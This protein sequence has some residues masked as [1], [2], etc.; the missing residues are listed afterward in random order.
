MR[1]RLSLAAAALLLAGSLPALAQAFPGKR[2]YVANDGCTGHAYRPSR[3]TLACGDG[4]LYATGISYRTYGQSVARASARIHLND[5]IPN[6][7]T[8]RFH[9][10]RGTL[11]L[12]DIVRC[13][14]RRLYYSRARYS[15]AGAHGSGLAD[16][17]P[18]KHCS[19]A[20]SSSPSR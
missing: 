10:Y 6:C 4:N 15:V 13:S 8:G 3:V 7:A 2:V 17:E 5:C 18:L 11:S 12:R 9:S 19:A 14:D 16:I 20:T 1:S